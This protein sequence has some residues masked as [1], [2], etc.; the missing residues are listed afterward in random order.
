[1]IDKRVVE[2][3]V[4]EAIAGTDKFVVEISITRSNT[5]FIYMDS[6][7]HI[8]ID[9]CIA[10]S[11]QVEHSLDREKEDFELQVSSYGLDRP[12]VLLRQ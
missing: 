1:M 8:T 2:K 4:Q 7:T 9:D 10:I 11:R 3:I 6:D 12:L 5:I